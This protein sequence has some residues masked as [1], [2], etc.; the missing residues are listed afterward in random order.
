MN[1]DYDTYQ[2]LIG[3]TYED[4]IVVKCR[5]NEAIE[6]ATA[7]SRSKKKDIPIYIDEEPFEGRIGIARYEEGTSSSRFSFIWNE[8]LLLNEKYNFVIVSEDDGAK[9]SMTATSRE[10]FDIAEALT[11]VYK[12][13]SVYIEGTSVPI[14][15]VKRGD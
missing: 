13:V 1:F 3:T 14:L 2:F 8:Y 7:L 5:V 6:M 12:K 15:E 9:F 4:G 11:N 10:I